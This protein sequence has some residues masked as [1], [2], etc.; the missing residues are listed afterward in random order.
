MN[1]SSREVGNAI[2]VMVEGH[3]DTNTSPDAQNYLDRLVESGTQKILISFEKTNYI[4]SAGL[5]VV[6]A[7]AKLLNKS[8]GDLRLCN[9]S[10]TVRDVFEIS[11]FTTI[12]NVF[13]SEKEAI[14]SFEP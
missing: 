9:L 14:D 2:L 12:L 3:L 5:R 7:T 11:G 8:G 4:S 1:I 10:S 6:L 13:D